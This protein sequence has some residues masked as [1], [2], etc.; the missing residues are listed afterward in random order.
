M[1]WI[2]TGIIAN[3]FCTFGFHRKGD[4]SVWTVQKADGIFYRH[5]CK[6]CGSR[7]D[8]KSDESPDE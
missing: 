8:E 5:T 2:V 6:R 7:W 4:V 3:I 1:K